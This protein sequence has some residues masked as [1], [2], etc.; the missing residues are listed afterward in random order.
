ML[1]NVMTRL[2]YHEVNGVQPPS[3]DVRC[4]IEFSEIVGFYELPPDEQYEIETI[5]LILRN[6]QEMRVLIS[7]DEFTAIQNEYKSKIKLFLN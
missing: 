1:L 4:S 2:F 6:N 5:R 7:F 3:K